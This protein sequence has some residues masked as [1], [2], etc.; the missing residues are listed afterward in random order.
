MK[1]ILAILAI[2]AFSQAKADQSKPV[3]YG[4]GVEGSFFQAGSEPELG[5]IQRSFKTVA[6]G[7]KV[8]KITVSTTDLP[9]NKGYD[10]VVNGR[11]IETTPK[12]WTVGF[13]AFEWYKGDWQLGLGGSVSRIM[14]DN[15]RYTQPHLVFG[16][17]HKSGIAVF[18]S[19]GKKDGEWTGTVGVYY[20]FGAK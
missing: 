2:L 11:K 14:T 19:L 12:R 10:I 18:N 13:Q 6:V 15:D 8:G 9:V 20:T 17:T 16:A 4:I 1:K 7:M 3:I 5:Q